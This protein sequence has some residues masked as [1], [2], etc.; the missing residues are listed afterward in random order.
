MNEFIDHLKDVLRLF[1]PFAAKRMFTATEDASRRRVA[2]LG[3]EVL[4]R[5]EITNPEGVI[6]QPIRIRGRQF[7]VIGVLAS[8]GVSGVGDGDNQILIPFSTGRFAWRSIVRDG[9]FRWIAP[10]RRD[11]EIVVCLRLILEPRKFERALR[12]GAF[13]VLNHSATESSFCPAPRR[14]AAAGHLPI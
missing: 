4:P 6:D 12:D 1:G 5:L 11:R 3:A 2:V 10:G 13:I 7:T 14:R 8:R 9:L